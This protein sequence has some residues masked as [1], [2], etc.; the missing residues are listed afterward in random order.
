MPTRWGGAVAAIVGLGGGVA[1][2]RAAVVVGVGGGAGASGAA[3][4]GEGGAAPRRTAPTWTLR[5]TRCAGS[6]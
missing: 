1:V 6:R 4:G 2:G 3:A 5:T